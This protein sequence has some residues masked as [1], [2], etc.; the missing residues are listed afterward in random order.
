MSTSTSPRTQCPHC[1]KILTIK[2]ESLYGRRTNCP[3]CREKFEVRPYGRKRAAGSKGASAATTALIAKGDTA[4]WPDNDFSELEGTAKPKARRRVKAEVVE[5][6]DY[7]FGETLPALPSRSTRAAA[8]RRKSDDVPERRRG[9]E[10]FERKRPRRI[11]AQGPHPF[12]QFIGWAAG[13]MVGGFIGA[14]IWAVIICA[15]GYEVGIVAWAVGGLTGL[16]AAFAANAM[17]DTQGFGSGV[18]A[19]FLSLGAIYMGKAIAITVLFGDV[20][21]G[22]IGPFFT[23]NPIDGFFILAAFFTAYKVGAGISDD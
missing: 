20:I 9:L 21:V 10:Q 7:G 19:A 22:I 6:E 14:V 23:L 8:T 11:E 17:G 1:Q 4:T 16:G 5:E 13:S 15:T 2:S 3:Q 18:T 12:V